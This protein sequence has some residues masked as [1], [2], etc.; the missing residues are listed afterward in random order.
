MHPRTCCCAQETPSLCPNPPK[1]RRSAIFLLALLSVIPSW[2]QEKSGGNESDSNP[3]VTQVTTGESAGVSP[4]ANTASTNIETGQPLLPS[5]SP[6]R[7]KHLSLLSFN[8][9]YIYDSNYFLEPNAP[10]AAKGS[11]ISGLMLYTFKVRHV[12]L[13]FQ[14]LPQFAISQ[15]GTQFAYANQ[16]FDAHTFIHLTPRWIVNLSDRFQSTPNNG[17]LDEASFIPNTS[18]GTA[19]RSSILTGARGSLTNTFTASADRKL[20]GR[21]RIS[22]LFQHELDNLFSLA[23]DRLAAQA[24]N[25]VLTQQR[26]VRAEFGWFRRLQRGSEVGVRYAYVHESFP[27]AQESTQLHGILASYSR[28][29]SASLR[30]RVEGGPTF[31]VSPSTTAGGQLSSIGTSYLAAASL[32]KTFR[33]ATAIVSYSRS[34]SFSGQVSNSLADRLEAS[35]SQ[36]FLNRLNLTIGAA[37]LT[38]GEGQGQASQGKSGWIQTDY[39][40]LRAWSIYSTYGY[41]SIGNGPQPS[42]ARS[43]LTSGVRWSFANLHR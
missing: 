14:Y 4:N 39:R 12:D 37:L 21:D 11:I 1:R 42:S 5:I 32:L 27:Q 29:L 28:R 36:R 18:D 24:G 35:Y 8:A 33:R 16:L 38:Q 13:D 3:P 30:L 19:L 20:N 6:L 31:P 22:L 43:L 15:A 10:V 25:P 2:A 17:N 23:E 7:W 41:T 40:L 9:T 34:S 26:N